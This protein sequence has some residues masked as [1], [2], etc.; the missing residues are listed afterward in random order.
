MNIGP[1]FGSIF[2]AEVVFLMPKF[3]VTKNRQKMSVV[4]LWVFLSHHF[5][6]CFA[7]EISG[8]FHGLCWNPSRD[9]RCGLFSTLELVSTAT[10]MS[11]KKQKICLKA[12]PHSKDVNI[13]Q[14]NE[15]F[16][17]TA[18]VC[19]G[20]QEQCLDLKKKHPT[21]LHLLL[22]FIFER[23]KRN[24]PKHLR[25]SKRPCGISVKTGWSPNDISSVVLGGSSQDGRKWF[26]TMAVTIQVP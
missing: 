22:S 12:L 4:R 14:A 24:D 6:G 10:R 18:K 21:S 19:K 25:L 7:V 16:D 3:V 1:F 26:I 17:K 2:P 13:Q 11:F 20:A 23:R 8:V 9:V 15:H 5:S